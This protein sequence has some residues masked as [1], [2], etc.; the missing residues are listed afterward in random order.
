MNPLRIVVLCLT[1]AGFAAG[2]IAAFW[3]YRASEVGVDPAW[4]KHEGGFEPVDAL[5]S[6]AGWLVGLLQAADVNQ[7]AAQWTAVSV[8][9]TGFASLLGLF[10]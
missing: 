6:Q 9:L 3:W 7:R 2:M 8:L 10:A 5:Q 4:S 1:L